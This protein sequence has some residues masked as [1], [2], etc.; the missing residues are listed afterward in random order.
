MA[1]QGEQPRVLGTKEGKKDKEGEKERQG[2]IV[3]LCVNMCA[4]AR[5]VRGECQIP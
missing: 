2:L 3:C 4:Y 5:E 1:I